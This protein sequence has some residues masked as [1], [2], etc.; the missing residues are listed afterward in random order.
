MMVLLMTMVIP[1]F[2][3]RKTT[4]EE[5]APCTC[6]AQMLPCL[7]MNGCQNA[8]KKRVAVKSSMGLVQRLR[9]PKLQSLP[10]RQQST[11]PELLSSHYIS[12]GVGISSGR[13]VMP[14]EG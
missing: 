10:R 6:G 9:H 3:A 13:A 8:E 5:E 11:S 7:L 14:W 12:A 1:Y 4:Q 2:L